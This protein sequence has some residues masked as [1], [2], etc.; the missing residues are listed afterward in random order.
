MTGGRQWLAPLATRADRRAM[1]NEREVLEPEPAAGKVAVVDYD[2]AWPALFGAHAAK[3]RAALGPLALGVEHV[4]STSVPGLAAKP[5]IDINLTVASSA[6]EGAY[7]P[8]LVAAGYR[9]IVREPD[10]FEHRMFKRGSGGAA[11]AANVHVFSASCPELARMG[12]MRDWLRASPE[13]L[14]LYAATKRA[15]AERDWAIVQD[16]ADAKSAVVGE[17]MAR[18]E[19]WAAGR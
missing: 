15:L 6:D 13:D 11:P 3:L 10:W 2:P 7:A 9:L 17:I 1:S 16:Y 19:A 5:V 12:L 4:G 18:A 8:Q 14:A